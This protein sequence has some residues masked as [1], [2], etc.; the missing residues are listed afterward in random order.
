M[1]TTRSMRTA[2]AGLLS[3]AVVLW[4]IGT[5]PAAARGVDDRPGHDKHEVQNEVDSDGDGISDADEVALGTD[6]DDPDT[7]HDGINDGDELAL[8]LDPLDPDSDHDG[9]GDA[10]DPDTLEAEAND[11]A[12]DDNGHDHP[13]HS[14]NR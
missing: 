8:G 2:T 5:M 11:A 3:A 4:G 12:P 10:D 13:G 6:P 7:D 9:I 14:K 1:K